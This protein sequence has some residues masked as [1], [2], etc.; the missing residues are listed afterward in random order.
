ML[1]KEIQDILVQIPNIPHPSVP[2]GK[3]DADNITIREARYYPNFNER[4]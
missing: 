1:E 2:V 3:S 4:R